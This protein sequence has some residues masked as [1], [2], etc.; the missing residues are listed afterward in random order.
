MEYTEWSAVYHGWTDDGGKP[1][2]FVETIDD[3]ICELN[4]KANADLIVAAVNAC[5]KLNPDNPMAV[6]EALPE[7]YEVLGT[8]KRTAESSGDTIYYLQNCLKAIARIAK[9]AILKVKVK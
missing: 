8:I 9:E 3:V 5:I 1:I 7:L 6:A 2:W 4:D